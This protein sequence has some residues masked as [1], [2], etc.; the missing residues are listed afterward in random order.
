MNSRTISVCWFSLRTIRKQPP[1]TGFL[2]STAGP[3]SFRA[4]VKSIVHVYFYLSMHQP[5]WGFGAALSYKFE[6]LLLQLLFYSCVEKKR[7]KNTHVVLL[8]LK[9]KWYNYTAIETLYNIEGVVMAI[10]AR[11]SL[12]DR[13][14]HTLRKSRASEGHGVCRRRKAMGCVLFYRV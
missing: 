12:S 9:Q 3:C 8:C 14:A 1:V 7:K 11:L 4:A 2:G 10:T 5:V 13:I 6:L